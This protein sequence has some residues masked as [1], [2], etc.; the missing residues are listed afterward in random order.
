MK[1]KFLFV[2]HQPQDLIGQW[3]LPK[4]FAKA[5]RNLGYCVSEL[6]FQD[7]SSCLSLSDQ[8]REASI[9]HNV[10]LCMYA[11]KSSQLDDLISLAKL[12]NPELVII[13]ELGDEPQTFKHNH[14][15]AIQS[16]IILTP[17]YK[18]MLA[19]SN[20]GL[21]AYWFTHWADS[22]IFYRDSSIQKDKFMST[23][24]GNRRYTF[25]LKLLLGKKFINQRIPVHENTRFYN[26]SHNAFQY[27]RWGEV[28]RRIFEASACGCCVLTNQLNKE[29]MIESIFKHNESIIY[30][31]GPFSLIWEILVLNFNPYKQKRI[32]SKA[33]K[34]VTDSHTSV[35]RALQLI[36]ILNKHFDA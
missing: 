14:N 30:Y 23:T 34:I 1:Y 7:S 6:T 19:W 18:S 36:I 15:R 11:G 25:L 13:N 12:S 16:D 33:L 2:Y 31:K 22:E 32:A 20:K 8:I 5:I 29:T 3:S 28:T 17:C 4:G 21:N 9:K 27:A 26:R 35:Q 10:L 24:V